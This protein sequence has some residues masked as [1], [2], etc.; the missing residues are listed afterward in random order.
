[1]SSLVLKFADENGIDR[2]ADVK[3][4]R[5]IIGRHS[6]CDLSIA[7]ARLSREHLLIER[8]GNDFVASDRGSSNGSELNGVPLDSPIRLRD[9]DKLDLGGGILIEIELRESL[10]A[11]DQSAGVPAS[12]TPK[13]IVAESIPSGKTGVPIVYFLAGPIIAA[14]LILFVGGLLFVLSSGSPANTR[15][16]Q[17]VDDPLA[18]DG[19]TKKIGKDEPVE[20][21]DGNES[22]EDQVTPSNIKQ[23][24]NSDP[25]PPANLGE[26]AKV[27]VYA[28][29]FLRR[30]AKNDSTAFLTSEQAKVLGGKIK[31][32]SSNPAIAT[33]LNSAKKNSS[34]IS[35][36]A[37][38]KNL[39]PEFVAVA[40][41]NK[42]GSTTGDVLQTAQGMAEILDKLVTQIGTEL[43]DDSLLIVA[44]YEQ[45]AAG[46]F[47]K[48]RNMLQGLTNEFPDSSRA[49][50]TIW[51]LHS[52]KK[53]SES[54]FDRALTF[55]AIGTVSQAPKEFGINAEALNF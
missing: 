18:D 42:L 38:S 25:A 39:A 30:I 52:K 2:R 50:R 12:E 11:T 36:L 3:A 46:E 47:L 28:A 53:I 29:K 40:A 41:V 6:G 31:Q 20:S 26:T 9:G 35:S 22:A 45:G 23:S 55:L 44:A 48:M 37:R 49:I 16:A 8:V 33:N 34:Q 19:P 5:F 7:D 32:I 43:S 24:G 14:V 1:M 54:D 13:P 27:E 4:D 21:V 51:F 15:A 10:A 17:D